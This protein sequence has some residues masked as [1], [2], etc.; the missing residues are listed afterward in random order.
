LAFVDTILLVD[1]DGINPQSTYPIRISEMKKDGVQIFGYLEFLVVNN[2]QLGQVRLAP[3]V[4]Q[5][6]VRTV[7][8][9][10]I[11]CKM[12]LERSAATT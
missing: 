4:G 12:S 1:T 3:G 11:A 5:S 9:E 2:E 8:P 10:S 7:I 6:I